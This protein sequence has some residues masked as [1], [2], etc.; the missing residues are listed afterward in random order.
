MIG[1]EPVCICVFAKPARPGLVK[2]RLAAELG[3]QRAADLARAFFSDT[4]A[5]VRAQPNA[6]SVLAATEHPGDSLALEADAAIWLQGDGDLGQRI[7]RILQRGLGLAPVAFAVGAD[8]P[9][10]PPRLWAAA[11]Q[12]ATAFDAVLGPAHDGGFYLLGLRR[13]PR[14][15]LADLPWSHPETCERTLARLQSAGFRVALLEPWFDVDEPA[16][17][18]RLHAMLTSGE[19]DAPCT[20]AL[21]GIPCQTEAAARAS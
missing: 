9:G 19:V 20:A 6:R 14:G 11:R 18:L 10:L 12:Q 8:S 16:D 4:W 7:E 2:T 3:L 21:L 1:P 13:C 15:L 5:A 17:L